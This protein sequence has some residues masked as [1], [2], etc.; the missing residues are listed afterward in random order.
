MN[1]AIE[2]LMDEHRL[3]ER[4]L[5]SLETFGAEI[6]GGLRPGDV[7]AEVNR[8]RVRNGADFARLVAQTRKGSNLLLLVQRDGNSRFV[9]VSPRQ[10]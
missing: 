1:K 5:G 10:P 3:I 7:I 9:V 8:E 2:V 6:E 4:V